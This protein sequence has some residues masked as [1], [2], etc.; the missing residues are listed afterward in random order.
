M[1]SVKYLLPLLLL[2]TGWTTSAFAQPPGTGAGQES[3]YERRHDETDPLPVR[4]FV[5]SKENIDVRQKASNLE[6]SGDVRF[7]WRHLNEEGRRVF[8]VE[9]S[10]GSESYGSDEG[11]FIQRYVTLQGSGAL[12]NKLLP[13][14]R[15]D[16]D[17]EFNFKLKYTFGRAWAAAHLQY[18]NSAGIRGFNDCFSDYIVIGIPRSCASISDPDFPSESYYGSSFSSAG[19]PESG[20]LFIVTVPRDGRYA[21]KGSGE[22]AAI[23]LKRAYMGYNIYA[24]GV[25]RLDVELGRRKLNDIFDSEI[26][27]G[28]RFDGI[29]FKYASAIDRVAE[30]YANVAAFIIDERVDHAGFVFEIGLLDMFDA[31]LDFKYSLIDWTKGGKNRCFIRHAE[32]SQFV[33]S[34]FTVNYHM[35]PEIY[36]KKIPVEFYGAFIIN[37]AAKKN[38]FTHHK[39]KNLGWYAGVL[40]GDVDKEGDWSF[41]ITYEYVQAQMASDA[42]VN[43]IGRNNVLNERLTD[44][45]PLDSGSSSS[46]FSSS[47]DVIF[48]RRGNTNFKGW[49]FEF[50]YAMTDNLSL[51]IIYEF[52]HAEDN[53]IG[54]RHYYSNAEIEAIY[55]F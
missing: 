18:D 4:E 2:V 50:L 55:A 20:D 26:Q 48:P 33:N 11:S 19:S 31:G 16:W 51:D 35:M 39:R 22:S 5:Q 47:R 27:F 17:V 1:R 32:G 53:H 30:W 23:N 12:D 13:V 14:S 43:G 9:N 15:N 38:I 44:I 42:D 52:T 28:C 45:L 3:D 7:E 41:D 10:S 34:Q 54:G 37:H 29:V 24:D 6:I 25:H 8:F 21:T 46:S 36:C 40:V 49:S